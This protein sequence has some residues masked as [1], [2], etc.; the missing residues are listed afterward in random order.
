[1]SAPMESIGLTLTSITHHHL[2][3]VKN[4]RRVYSFIQRRTPY[5][6][7]ISKKSQE[8]LLVAAT[9][10]NFRSSTHL[11]PLPALSVHCAGRAPISVLVTAVGGCPT[12]CEKI[13]Y[14]DALFSF[15]VAFMRHSGYAAFLVLSY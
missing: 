15:D 3:N 8:H 9:L 13:V 2:G 12:F 11:R 14:D 6:K 4:G 7:K 1:M 5:S 10:P